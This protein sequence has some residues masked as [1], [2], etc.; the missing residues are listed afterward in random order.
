MFDSL[1]LRYRTPQVDLFASS[2]T[3]QLPLYLTYNRRTRTGGPDA[4]T[5]DWNQW[6]FVYLFSPPVTPVLLRVMLRLRVTTWQPLKRGKSRLGSLKSREAGQGSVEDGP[7]QRRKEGSNLGGQTASP[8]LSLYR[9]PA[10]AV[11]TGDGEDEVEVE[12]EDGDEWRV[13]G[14]PG[15]KDLFLGRDFPQDPR[16][17]PREEDEVLGLPNDEG[18]E[19]VECR[20]R[21]EA[22]GC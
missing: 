1:T 8:H 13:R 17:G 15:D 3:A 14:L 12:D 10:L 7:E 5:E 4:F 20:K 2:D 21:S 16:E 19:P 9:H 6:D 11:L 18:R 22:W